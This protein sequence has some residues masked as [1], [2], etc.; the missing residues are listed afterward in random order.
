L[1]YP[2]KWDAARR[3]YILITGRFKRVW[4]VKFI[5]EKI[6]SVVSN[7]E[8]C[9]RC[10]C[11]FAVDAVD[12]Q[13]FFWYAIIDG[14]SKQDVQACDTQ[15]FGEILKETETLGIEHRVGR[16]SHPPQGRLVFLT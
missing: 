11:D 4:A 9:M 1:G 2:V 3:S 6:N 15:I 8:A 7:S 14:E 12:R 10:K 5:T 13:T 16:L